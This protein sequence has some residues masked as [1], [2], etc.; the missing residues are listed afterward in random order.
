MDK[1]QISGI[2]FLAMAVLHLVSS[3]LDTELLRLVTKPLLMPL[4]LAWFLYSRLASEKKY[5]NFIIAALVSSWIGDIFLLFA[6]RGEQFF[7]GGLASFLI[8]QLLYSAAFRFRLMRKQEKL[9]SSMRWVIPFPFL[10]FLTVFFLF[11]MPYL[12]TMLLP[13][14]V[15]GIV[16][17][18]MGILAAMN[19]ALRSKPYFAIILCGAIFFII[20][21][22]LLAINKFVSEIPGSGF[23]IM[24]TYLTAQTFIALGSTQSSGHRSTFA[25]KMPYGNTEE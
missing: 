6:S 22:A 19:F 10:L 3:M 11:L 21:D 1:R 17:T 18:A 4:L 16:I 8:T 2:A 12:G 14:A 13:V 15:Y 20:S 25:A 7:I 24:L 5:S 23:W 9:N